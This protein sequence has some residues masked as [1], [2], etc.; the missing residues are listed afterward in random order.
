MTDFIFLGSKITVDGYCSHEIQMLTLW[1]ENYDKPR[2]CIKKQRHY[3]A[4]KGLCGWKRKLAK[5]AYSGSLSPR[6]VN[7]HYVTVRSLIALG[8]PLTRHSLGRR[9]LLI[10]ELHLNCGDTTDAS[11]LCPLGQPWE[12]KHVC[13][14]YGSSSLL[15]ATLN[16][17][18]SRLAY[19][20]FSKQHE[21]WNNWHHGQDQ[22]DS[23]YNQNYD[24]SNCMY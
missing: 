1:K 18:S 22:Q 21:Q 4:D 19:P 6:F 17:P 24:F 12:S 10:Y 23:L 20:G 5:M 14:S 13:G 15:P 8:M 9:L 11:R 2:Q 16:P 7:N 3:Y